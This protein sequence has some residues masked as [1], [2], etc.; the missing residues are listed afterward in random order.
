MSTKIEKY[1]NVDTY[2]IV[3]FIETRKHGKKKKY[4]LAHSYR[5]GKKVR[6]ISRYLGSNLSE[7]ELKS[8]SK[9]AEEIILEQIREKHPFELSEDELKEYKKYENKIEIRH[10]QKTLDWGRFT[11]DF[12]YN[13]NAIEGSTVEYEKAKKLIEK[14]DAPQNSEEIETINVSNAVNFIRKARQS[15]SLGLIKKLHFLCF[16]KTK[17]FAG[18]IRNTKVVIKDKDGNIIHRGA[19]PAQIEGLLGELAEWYEKH[20]GR[21][22]PLLLAA[23]VHNQFEHIHPFQD[24]NGRVGRLLLNYILLRHNYPP[25][26][27]K[28]RDKRRYYKTL[29]QF[30]KTGDIKPTLR[31][32]ASQYGKK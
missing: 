28:L 15:L 4:Y 29:S 2:I 23:I 13:T 26:S 18:K 30:G 6:R 19:A 25:I 27:I 8:L 32:L 12:T 14:K 20:K 7:K 16:N 10:L 21:Y 9:R 24:G 1:I 22:P 17:P 11:K 3:M 5:I 31:L